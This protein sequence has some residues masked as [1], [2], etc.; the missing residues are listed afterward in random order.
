M[1]GRRPPAARTSPRGG[2]AAL[3]Q[4][5]AKL[6]PSDLDEAT[7]AVGQRQVHLTNL[8]KIFWP[9]LGVSK[10]DLIRYYVTV[11]PML[12]PHLRDRAMVMRRYPNG[13]DGPSF[14]MKRAPT[15]RP[16]WIETCAIEH[17]SGNVIEFPMIQDLP[18]LLWVV[19]LGCI[20]L[21]QWYA[22]CD[23]VDRPDYVHFDLDPGPGASFE[24]VCESA[25]LLEKALRSLAFPTYVKTTGSRGLHIY[26]PIVRR[27]TQ[28][29]V[30]EF[31]KHFAL[32]AAAR[33]P[34]LMT[35]EYRVAKRPKGRVLIDYNQNAWG[36]TL[37]S[38]YSVR[39]APRAS[40]SMPVT[41]RELAR[42]IALDDFRIDTVP[43]RLA[44]L[45]DLWSELL[46]P[47]GPRADLGPF[48]SP[49]SK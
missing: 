12:L 43:P 49:T 25:L 2:R 10:G 9:A 31:A 30:W 27:P 45:G 44:R 39:P 42:G 6:I 46:P 28:H 48:L 47:H 22:R 11:A 16:P 32:E 38:I 4:A 19:N 41:W 34:Q 13:A 24:D 17:A 5:A 3:A 33:Q 18:A 7:V 8:R 35:T 14:F 23:D 1:P 15:P 26:V 29:Q 36:R 20:D 21:N 40:V 37:A